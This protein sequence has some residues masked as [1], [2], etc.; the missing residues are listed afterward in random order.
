M[1]RLERG[2]LQPSTALVTRLAGAIGVQPGDLFATTS[3][4]PNAPTLRPVERRLL[5]LVRELPE[6]LVEDVIKGVRLLTDV[7]R[8][9]PER[10]RR[11][12]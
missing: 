3:V 9:T 4:K 1:S 2:R 11:H 6:P 10:P 7:G 5:Q 12:R 8:H